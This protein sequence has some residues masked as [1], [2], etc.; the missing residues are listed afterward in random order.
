MGLTQ[1]DSRV[2][3]RSRG[4]DRSGCRTRDGEPGRGLK[5]KRAMRPPVVVVFL[6]GRRDRPGV[7]ESV[8]DILGEALVTESAMQVLGETV[9]PGAGT[10]QAT[11]AGGAQPIDTRL[12][13]TDSTA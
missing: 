2:C 11:R 3:G 6:R 10:R 5:T 7:V 9:V 13:L 4:L 1:T 8:A 12:T